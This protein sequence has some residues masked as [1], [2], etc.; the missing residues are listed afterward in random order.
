MFSVVI[1][2]YNKANYVQKTI[3]SV[4]NQTFSDFE[5]IL[6][7]DGSTDNSLEVV[8]EINDSRI[9]IFSKE[10]RGVSAARNYGIKKAQYEY[11]TF[12]DADDCWLP[13]YLETIKGMIK[14]YPQAGFF[15][16]SYTVADKLYRIDRLGRYLAKGEVLLIEDY[17]KSLI[18]FEIHEPWTGT[19]CVKKFLFDKIGGFREGIKRGEDTDMWLRLS[20]VT[21]FVW[22]NESKAI[23]Y[24]ETENNSTSNISYKNTVP[25]WEWYAFGSSIYLK[26][27]V[28]RCLYG[29]FKQFNYRDKLFLL[30]KVN[31]FYA[32]IHL[33]CLLGNKLGIKTM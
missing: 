4:L 29:Y 24:Y 22:K 3:E 16:T 30:T 18:K 2:L 32:S 5:V 1:P 23:Y 12:L 27:F 20:F 6:V 8:K 17:C 28:N 26:F 13:D 15:A 11:I 10:N 33:L 14:Q 21:P 9:R 7:N 25:C 31:W 19:I